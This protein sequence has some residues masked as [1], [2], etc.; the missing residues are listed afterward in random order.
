ML[1]EAPYVTN[2]LRTIDQFYRNHETP[3]QRG[4]LEKKIEHNIF[5]NLNICTRYFRLYDILNA[6]Y[7]IKG[8][9]TKE[10]KGKLKEA[11]EKK[12]KM[13]MICHL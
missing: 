11:K 10:E 3:L 13:R 9:S 6:W 12:E 8:I 7:K 5:G 4:T 1:D 2:L